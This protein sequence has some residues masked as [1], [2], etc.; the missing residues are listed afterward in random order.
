MAEGGRKKEEK[1][2]VFES[3]G[4][5]HGG[6]K[7]VRIKPLTV[8]HHAQL[9]PR[10]MNPTVQRP[11]KKSLIGELLMLIYKG[12]FY[13]WEWKQPSKDYHDPHSLA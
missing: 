12:G 4:K 8:Q 7:G 3:H 9:G 10:S 13:R 11:G 6:R 2:F 5:Q 1:K